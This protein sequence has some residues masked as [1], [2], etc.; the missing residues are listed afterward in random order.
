M[1]LSKVTLSFAD[2][3]PVGLTRDY[4]DGQCR[5]VEIVCL[6][7]SE[8]ADKAVL[9][10]SSSY[11]AR[12]LR[13]SHFEDSSKA[14]AD[15]KIE[16]GK[17]KALVKSFLDVC[18]G[19]PCKLQPI[20]L[21]KLFQFSIFLQADRIIKVIGNTLFECSTKNPRLWV[22][23]LF[24]FDHLTD[25]AIGDLFLRLKESS[26]HGRY[27]DF[28]TKM[29]LKWLLSEI[30]NENYWNGELTHDDH[31]PLMYLQSFGT[32]LQVKETHKDLAHRLMLT[33]FMEFLSN[34][35]EINFEFKVSED[36]SPAKSMC[37]SADGYTF[38][39][40]YFIFIWLSM[41]FLEFGWQLFSINPFPDTI[42][43][44]FAD[45]PNYSYPKIATEMIPDWLIWTILIC[46]GPVI[47]ILL[48]AF[49]RSYRLSTPQFI[50]AYGTVPPIICF[51]VTALKFTVAEPRPNF[52]HRCFDGPKSSAQVALSGYEIMNYN[53]SIYPNAEI[54]VSSCPNENPTQV[55]G[56]LMSFP[57]DTIQLSEIEGYNVHK[58]GTKEEVP[59]IKSSTLNDW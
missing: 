25:P 30:D 31:I 9:T 42:S 11:I 52:L 33:R 46:T 2:F 4:L 22:G 1:D 58:N 53:S 10:F 47:H 3:V 43:I 44:P 19:V 36:K 50:M 57:S 26:K 7:G 41:A 29:D 37:Y 6:D 56:G 34:P 8:F 54:V 18:Y 13:N 38:Q 27:Q 35:L 5:E 55:I 24:A 20:E 15:N 39:I 16:L 14:I 32:M 40:T 51:L 49:V 23:I 28:F 17:P 12:F 21:V 48:L 59:R 45:I